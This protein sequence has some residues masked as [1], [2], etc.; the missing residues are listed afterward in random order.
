MGQKPGS[1]CPFVLVATQAFGQR[2]TIGWSAGFRRL[3]IHPKVRLLHIANPQIAQ[4]F[5]FPVRRFVPNFFFGCEADDPM[6]AV[7]FNTKLNPLEARLGAMLSSDI[8]HWDVTNMRE[9]V[10][11]AYEMVE[12]ELMTDEDF[13]DFTFANPVRFFAGMNPDFFK[14]TAVES[15]V[16]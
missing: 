9:V 16:A 4:G 2:R 12:K 1:W 6:S 5:G 7:A 10:E 15:A 11:E 14:G 13:R 8:G 3:T